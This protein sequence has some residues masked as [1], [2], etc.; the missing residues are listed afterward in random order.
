MPN[1]LRESER[2]SHI[3]PVAPLDYVLKQLGLP[4]LDPLL[5]AI[6]PQNVISGALG[7]PTPGDLASAGLERIDSQVRSMLS[8]APKPPRPPLPPLP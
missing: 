4:R 8:R 2:V 3:A 5:V 1:I 6:S 7:F